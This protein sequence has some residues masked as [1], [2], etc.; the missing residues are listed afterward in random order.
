M[1]AAIIIIELISF[2]IVITSLRNS[3]T[4]NNPLPVPTQFWVK[5]YGPHKYESCQRELRQGQQC[6][7]GSQHASPWEA[8]RWVQGHE[9]QPGRPTTSCFPGALSSLEA[10]VPSIRKLFILQLMLIPSIGL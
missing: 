7:H 9:S 4:R 5:S 10:S 6:G 3:Q 1:R 8:V 2:N